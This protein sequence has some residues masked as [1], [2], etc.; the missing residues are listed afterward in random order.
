MYR[1]L[2][3]YLYSDSKY[4]GLFDSEEEAYNQVKKYN[5]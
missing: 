2:D 5:K 4:L 1:K 3:R